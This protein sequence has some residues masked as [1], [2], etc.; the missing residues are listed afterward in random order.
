LLGWLDSYKPLIVP[1]YFGGGAFAIFLFRQFF[2]TIPKEYDEAAK[3]DGASSLVIFFRILV[4]MAKPVFITMAIFSFMGSW[5]AFFGPLIYLNT[6]EK[7]TL[8]LGLQY[9]RRVADAG[10]EATEHLLMA[11]AMV[12]TLPCVILF[13]VLQRYFVRGVVLSGLKG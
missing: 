12:M 5:N 6:T 9:F 11:G 13:L 1:S 10:G 7:Y 4:P 3:M 2:L 8:Q